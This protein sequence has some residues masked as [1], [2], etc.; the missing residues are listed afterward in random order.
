MCRGLDLSSPAPFFAFPFVRSHNCHIYNELAL[1][2]LNF[3][4]NFLILKGISLDVKAVNGKRQSVSGKKFREK[5]YGENKSKLKEEPQNRR[6]PI[7]Q[8]LDE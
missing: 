7:Y 2:E 6:E 3:W 8:I 1:F 5:T 4:E